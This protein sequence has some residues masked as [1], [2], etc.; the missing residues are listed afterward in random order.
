MKGR[1]R[2][3]SLSIPKVIGRENKV[4]NNKDAAGKTTSSTLAQKPRRNK[5]I[6]NYF[7][8]RK[9]ERGM[10]KMDEFNIFKNTNDK[11]KPLALE[12]RIYEDKDRT[13]M[14]EIKTTRSGS[15]VTIQWTNIND[16]NQFYYNGYTLFYDERV[17][18]IKKIFNNGG[19]TC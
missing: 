8:T 15:T 6:T 10:I 7:S 4:E 16:R 5:V 3:I 17:F 13:P 2:L 1:K 18:K 12:V 14:A 9:E 11:N 19:Q